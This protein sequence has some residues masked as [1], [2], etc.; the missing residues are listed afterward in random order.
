[1]DSH[2]AFAPETDTI[3]CPLPSLTGRYSSSGHSLPVESLQQ[4][5]HPMKTHTSTEPT[6]R[7]NVP[8][9]IENTELALIESGELLKKSF[10]KAVATNLAIMACTGIFAVRS[11]KLFWEKRGRQWTEDFKKFGT[12]AYKAMKQDAF[13]SEET[14]E[15]LQ[16]LDALPP[17]NF[18]QLPPK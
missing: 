7:N 16:F 6:S 1:M 5:E 13:G 4:T 14:I 11:T 2:D 3:T 9:K 8:A 17:N 15:T 18:P 12:K 10:V